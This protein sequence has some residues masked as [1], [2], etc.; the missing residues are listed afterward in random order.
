[1][2]S[3]RREGIPAYFTIDAGPN[4][5]V[6]TLPDHATEVQARLRAMS[7]VKD[8]ITCQTGKGAILLGDEKP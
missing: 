8:I 7:E 4:V 2:R 6:I 5:H 1:V 3:W